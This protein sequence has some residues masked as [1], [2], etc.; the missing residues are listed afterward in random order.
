MN[1]LSRNAGIDSLAEG[2]TWWVD[3][4]IGLVLLEETNVVRGEPFNLVDVLDLDIVGDQASGLWC[5]RY[6]LC[7]DTYLTIGSIAGNLASSS[8]E[9]APELLVLTLFTAVTVIVSP[10]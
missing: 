3:S 4:Q 6:N 9:H 1:P 7:C 5:S 10:W 8:W 2:T